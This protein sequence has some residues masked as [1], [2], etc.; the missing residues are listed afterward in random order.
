MKDIL[1]EIKGMDE[2]KMDFDG[3]GDIEEADFLSSTDSEKVGAKENISLE[4][5][6]VLSLRNKAMIDLDYMSEL[7]GVPKKIIMTE[8]TGKLIWPD[9]DR[10][11][12]S[13][14]LERCF[15]SKQQL[16]KGNLYAKLENAKKW[17]M[18]NGHFRETILLLE[19]ALP[20]K[21]DP[22]QIHVNLGSTWVEP[23]IYD[24]FFKVLFKISY[25]YSTVSFDD[26]NGKWKMHKN[27]YFNYF[28]NNVEYGTARISATKIIEH[29]MNAKAIKIYDTVPKRDGTK[30]TER[31]INKAETLAAQEKQNLI[32]KLWQDYIDKNASVKKRLQKL[33]MDHYGYCCSNY[34]GG[35]LS[36]SDMNKVVEPYPHQRNAVARILLNRNTL[37]AHKVGSGKSLEIIAGV[38]ELERIGL[39]KKAL[40]VVPPNTFSDMVASYKEFYPQD[41]VL[42][43]YAKKDFTPA[44]RPATL[45]KIKSD[46]YQVILMSYASFDMLTL[47]K[48]YILS[49]TMDIKK[50]TKLKETL[51]DT[52]TSCFD[53][54]GVD[55][56]VV[57]ESHNYK[58]ITLETTG[59]NIVGVHS[60]G[61][62]KAD[63]MLEKVEYIQ[64][65]PTGHVIFSTG[66]P[67]TNSLADL[68]VLQK[69]LQPESLA[70]CKL[71]SF[72]NWI[73][74]FCEETHSFEIDV[75]S[76]NFR[77]TTRF[78][79]FHNLPE[80][81]A[82]F[83][84]VCDF[85]QN[86]DGE[87]ELPDF[88]GY[89]DTLVHKSQTQ[90][91]YIEELVERTEKIRK[92]EVSL[93]DDN[94]LKVTVDG[95]KCA[96]DVR[97][98]NPEAK[99][100][101]T[102]NKCRVCASKMSEVY[103][104][105]PGTTQIGFCDISTP[106]LGFNIYDELKKE[107]IKKGIPGEEI[108]FIH[109]ADTETKKTSIEKAFNQGKIRILLGSTQKLGT[110]VNVQERLIAVHHLDVPFRP[111]DM[112]QREGRILRQGNLNKEVYIFRYVTES[113]FDSYSW[114]LLENK[115][116]FIAQFLSGSL[117][118]LHREEKDTSDTVLGYA[119]I[120]ALAVGNPLIRER[121]E[122]A[123]ELERMHINQRQKR[124]ELQQVKLLLEG[125]PKRMQNKADYIQKLEKDE[126]FYKRNKRKLTQ[127]EK[128]AFGTEL[129]KAVAA[130]GHKEKE[131]VFGEYQNFDVVLPA[132]MDLSKPYVMLKRIGS[133]TYD[134]KM[135]GDKAL[136]CSMRLDYV[137]EH[138]GES[139]VK[140]REQY[141]GL[142][143]QQEEAEKALWKGN[144]YDSKVE[145][146]STKLKKL[147]EKL[148]EAI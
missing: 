23:K 126:E 108:A 109:D 78:S 131:T 140:N 11:A 50:Y 130:N 18:M 96:L 38:H 9:A 88:S 89:I 112:V 52:E 113:S 65:L 79:K 137:L 55:I 70:V 48:E 64:S 75:D 142:I 39:A 30:G 105:F 147:D 87:L 66:T 41:S 77:L 132:Y 32:V 15:V 47:S 73:N 61:S 80:L 121:V 117:S 144:E 91:E 94:L 43:I 58:N 53:K 99:P 111:A 31:V 93:T 139:I 84:E 35:F 74:C 28:I 95:R 13:R 86:D 76:Q 49:K 103:Y 141:E 3:W 136:G 124:A 4:D 72:A 8:L 100:G 21:V 22:S 98:V 25:P 7:T 36:F 63:N 10:Y 115:Q 34:D 26:Q 107:L 33:Y 101:A 42:A 1:E 148:K 134:V 24:D 71:N 54:L 57:D 46:K 120:K 127:E 20:D 45:E 114:Q 40:I 133:N 44:S 62:K 145:S 14:D 118:A 125:L 129:L 69:Y 135:D 68:Y 19:A 128:T 59:E 116:Q 2:G 16:L 102:D 12:L 60:T 5:S 56:L 90:K 6:Y 85:Y 37:I 97:L 104:K 106:K 67:I 122:T 82:M 138:F 110:G 81:M 51:K 83:S 119:E 17:N 123:N 143:V 92:H 146:L 29:T 27:V